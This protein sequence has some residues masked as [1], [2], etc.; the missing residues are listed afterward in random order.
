VQTEP[1][2]VAI[3]SGKDD[4]PEVALG[5]V[6]SLHNGPAALFRQ[7]GSIKGS[8]KICPAEGELRFEGESL[9]VATTPPKNVPFVV[10]ALSS[11]GA[12]AIFVLQGDLLCPSSP[13]KSP[14]LARL[15][16]AQRIL[17]A[18]R[19]DLLEASRLHHPLTAAAEWIIDNPYLIRTQVNEVR[20]HLPRDYAKLLRTDD[21]RTGE[22]R[23]FRLAKELAARAD[24]AIDQGN[25]ADFL[26]E[27]QKEK[28]LTVGE[29]WLFPLLLRVA[30]IEGLAELAQRISRSQNLSELAC[31]WANRLAVSSRGDAAVFDRIV[32]LLS[33]EPRAREPYFVICLSEQLQDEE[34][35]LAPLQRWIEKQLNASVSELVRRE[36]TR[37][38][39]ERLSTANAFGSLRALARI[40]FS[41]IF[42]AVSAVDA[43]LRLDPAGVYSASDF[44]TRDRC[45][46]VVEQIARNS[47]LE[48]TDVAR[49]AVSLAASEGA[50]G[51]DSLQSQVSYYLLDEGVE[52]LERDTRASTPLRVRAMRVMRQHGTE[53]YLGEITAITAC[54]LALAC[55]FAWEGGVHRP[56]LLLIPAALALFPL[57]EL[58]I[59]IINSLVIALF[60]PEPL[61]K[62]DFDAGI[63]REDATLVVVPMML[64]AAEAIRQE[65]D[66]L[67]VRFLANQEKHIQFSLFSDFTDSP[68]PVAPGDAA[69][70]EIARSGIDQLNARYP[71]KHFLLFHRPRT[72]S[73][74]EQL[75]I[76]QERKRGKIGDLNEY[77]C[78]ARPD[79]LPLTGDLLDPIQY[80]I[81]LDSDTQLPPGT[82][83]RMIATIAHP[84][85]RALL[86][87][88][89]HARRR[90]Y[91]VIQP[92]VSVAL[93]GAIASRFTR[94][95]AETK[96]TDPY[97]K[98]VSDAHQDL[99]GEAT[100]H[101]KAIYDVH[102]FREAVGD[103]FPAETILS[104]DLIEGAHA[105]VA[106]ATDIELFENLPLDYAG[107]SK[108]EHRWI[109]GDWQIA[110]W[111][112]PRVP[113]PGGH[114]RPN[115]LSAINRWRIFDNLR[116]SLV[117]IA[118]VLLLL[119]GWLTAAAHGTWSLVVGLA[120]VIPTLAPLMD[121]LARKIQGTALRWRGSEAAFVRALVAVAFLPHQAWIA[122]D[123]I[124]RALYRV[125]VSRRKLLE[126]Q[127]AEEGGI[128]REAHRHSIYLQ[129]LLIS[130]ASL[131]LIVFLYAKG[132]FASAAVFLGLWIVA[133]MLVR[134]L[135]HPDV[136]T[137]RR[138]LSRSDTV[139]LRLLARRTWRFFDDL[140][141]TRSNW[142]PP[143][144]TQLALRVEVAQRTSPTNIG[145]WLTSALA[146]TDLG[147][148]TAEQFLE[149]GEQTMAT[150]G[151]LERYEGH[152]LNWYDTQTLQPLW[153]RYVSTVDSGN[154]MATLWVVSQGCSQLLRRPIVGHACLR[155]LQDTLSILR[156]TYG[157]D[158]SIAAPLQE[159][160][161]LAQK[162]THGHF[163]ISRLMGS[164]RALDGIRESAR[165]HDP[166]DERAY[167]ALRAA[168]ELESWQK[169]S[170]RYLRWMRTLMQPPDSFLH[171]LAPEAV[172][173]RRKAAHSVPSLLDLANG[174]SP[175]LRTIAGWRGPAAIPA[176]VSA[177]LDQLIKEIQEASA[178][179][180]Q[181]VRRFEAFAAACE[182][183]AVGM[184]MRFLYDNDRRLFTV[185]YTVGG[186]AQY[187]SHYDLLASECRLASLVA[188]AKG[189][190]PIQHWFSMSRTRAM[191]G[192]HQVLLSWS[193][194]MFEYL[195]PL[196][197][198]RT[199]DNS[200]LDLACREA[201]R[202][203]IAYGEE[204]QVPWGCSESA[205]S[206]L[207]ANKIYQY[208]A[209][210][211]PS[212]ALKAGVDEDM[213]VAPY[214]T[215][216]A[217]LVDPPK[218]LANLRQLDEL[219]LSGPMGLYE[220]IDF[221]RENKENG[222]PGVPIYAYMAHHQGMSLAAL[223]DVLHRGIMRQRFHADVRVRAVESLLFEGVPITR[224]PSEEVDTPSSPVRLRVTE[225]QA[226]RTWKKEDPASPRIHLQGN[227]RYALMV[228]NSGGGYSQWNGFD[229]T[230]WR[231]DPAID[232]G[233]SYLYIK[234]LSSHA[235]W[236]A[237]QQ[238]VPGAADENLVRFTTD[239][240]EFQR[241][242]RGIETLLAVTVADDDV[243]LR[244]LTVTNQSKRSRQLELTSYIE[245]AMAPHAWD[246][247]HPAFAKMFVQTERLD[248]DVLIAWRRMRE[249]GETPIWTAHLITGAE[250]EILHETDRAKFL[251]RGNTPARPDAVRGRL[252][253][254]TGTVLDP[255]F[256]LS[257]RLEL[258][259]RDRKEITFLTIA[260]SSREEL[261]SI[262]E[263]YRRPEIC[264]RAFEIAWTRS[265]LAFRYLGI[266]P[267]AA[268][269]FQ[270][271]AG[272]LLFPAPRLRPPPDR[273]AQNQLGQSALW[274]HGIS[275]DLPILAVTIADPRNLPLVRELLLAHT[276]CRLLGF[277][278]DLVVLNQEGG[279]YDRPLHQKL[280]HQIE[281]H[282]TE[283]GIDR[284]GGV[285]LRDWDA[286]PE[287]NRQ[288]ILASA[289]VVL[290]GSRGSLQQQ[291][292]GAASTRPLPPAFVPTG[293]KEEPSPP[294]PFLELPYF[295]G[296]G[297]F[298]QDGREY[299][300]Y[301]HD[302]IC[303]PSPWVNVIANP[304]FGTMVSESG[305]GWT[306]HGNSQANRLTPW[307]NDPVTDP[308][309]EVIYLRDEETGAL[310]TPTAL[311][312]REQDAYRARH[313]Q[314]YTVFEHNSHAIEQELI[315]FVPVGPQRND[316]VKLCRLRLRNASS[317]LRRLTVTYFAEW[318]LGSSRELQAPHVNVAFDSD[319]GALF[320]RQSWSG[321]YTR[322]IAFAASS[323][324]A[325]SY[326][327]DR[328]QFLG[329]TGSVA[330]PAALSR[331]NLDNRAIAGSDPCTALQVSVT[332][333]PGK[334]HDI[335]FMLGQAGSL[336]DVRALIR[337]YSAV[338]AVED[339]LRGTREWWEQTLGT[340][341]VRTPV[342]SVDMLMNR[343]LQYQAL[344]CR[345]WARSA[346][347]QSSGAFGFRDQLQDSMAV[348]YAA[349]E[350][351]RQ[352]ILTAAARQFTEGDV[353]H[354]WHP[355]IGTGVRTRCS[356]DF[357]W[358][359][360]VVAHYIKITGDH[361][362]LDAEL[363]FLEAPELAAHEQ[364]RMLTPA[365][366]SNSAPLW[367]H[368]SRALQRG[369]RLGSHSLPL[370][371]N[372]DWNDG[373]NR[374][375]IEGKGES[376][377]LAWFL[378]STLEAFSAA[379]GNRLSEQIR[380]TWRRQA[381]ELTSA[382]SESAWDGEWYLRGFFDDGSPLGSHLDS[383][384]KIDS[385]AQSWAVL[386]GAADPTHA[387][388]AMES[389]ERMLV[390]EGNQLVKLF[391]P[392]FDHSEPN[393]GYIMSYPP[394]LRE[395]GGQY[396]HGSLWMASAWARLGQGDH[397]VHLLTLMNPVEH[398]RDP[399]MAAAYKGE[400]YVCPADVYTAPGRIGQSG[401]TWYTGSAAWMYRIW[402]EDVLG[403]H[404]SG[405]KLTMNPV[406][407][408]NWQGFQIRYR[409]HSATYQ[410]DIERTDEAE[411]SMHLDG[412]AVEAAELSLKDD[413]ALHKVTVRV[414][415]APAEVEERLLSKVG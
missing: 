214:A 334:S 175:A 163:L 235:V 232:R 320:A 101:G 108:R 266:G 118:S 35:A 341:Q 117:P 59:Q 410:I 400:P 253:G 195:M 169:C 246:A 407:P 66:K 147:Y 109:R 251:G 349:P 310:W 285:F 213:V 124:V 27:S 105:G 294:L 317:H 90:G 156:E 233:G 181:T 365:I 94:I 141:G 262:V 319:S 36:H 12:P 226:E 32:Q 351:A 125:H 16:R 85:N 255:V 247:S 49:R 177:W 299:G 333:E 201:V 353:Q 245:L 412:G 21:S 91:T 183:L 270:E 362:I 43:E 176:E 25:L 104:H 332:I 401:W 24:F 84:L 29:L 293:G 330:R 219:G 127:P 308:Q 210:G 228:T 196:I 92:R 390:D 72:W 382:I 379:V 244:R 96:G 342:L 40:D 275:G 159:L 227:G 374:V 216:L 209:F 50:K 302:R 221:G 359:P 220:S 154:L 340:L 99:F 387:R 126:W 134:W 95:F 237:S 97:C 192:G 137:T 13:G 215:M 54:L 86:D 83:R 243:E 369:W 207:D 128:F 200:L 182:Q 322:S 306:W 372:G 256:S 380:Q 77:L 337:R 161:H 130:A 160:R 70:L 223:D 89:T 56:A 297:G 19:Q 277:K 110:P 148:L 102:A 268:H 179:A 321:E 2:I 254:S 346:L 116:R 309:S 212:L 265:Q 393:P 205:F 107:Y 276:F 217:L 53:F 331:K 394:G 111:I 224:P 258:D 384:A 392:P 197:F 414:P 76:G 229:V 65:L 203:Q 22:P 191:V 165:W 301:L 20:R 397:A 186:P 188:I 231:A 280:E 15:K 189:D 211:V 239:R 292:A 57:S 323:P 170:D 328:V 152:L 312:I 263:K 402:L 408:R 377:W 62:L 360:A 79:G 282:S 146:A 157:S 112:F 190:A 355:E 167:W 199:F 38:A 272:Y 166:G 133:P 295:N 6:R 371:G 41:A 361:E 68:E 100:F 71:G 230:R 47:G 52:Q 304:G 283:T 55:R 42:E 399:Q 184:N 358:L 64:S 318:V 236:S 403:F 405:A 122:A 286:L 149:R 51:T 3:Y 44:I 17:E 75:W 391:T 202:Q 376:V 208:R 345:M 385:I 136:P 313:G 336:E 45:R 67:E 174:G 31:F 178:A 48:E 131:V 1:K 63:P 284:P 250:G 34:D 261:L 269:R 142:L 363:P 171:T 123:A 113:G 260:A 8:S 120:V 305:L 386:S 69:L 252:S 143:D 145:L 9:I 311:P 404:L 218:A 350:L 338:P 347:Y 103:R 78:G 114:L 303:T 26:R 151:K 162:P 73:Q 264:S 139:Y 173:V 206:A 370:F 287:Q 327:G 23:A 135:A 368:C 383:E 300:I 168:D 296:L 389:A 398:S 314:G 132:T 367:E 14:I 194:T 257:C 33:A 249:P 267:S 315:V 298:T 343:W 187:T 80:V 307:H 326:S 335:V 121:R 11:A 87:P 381:R 10:K 273:L 138:D 61:P 155:G 248:G 164:S 7:D 28:P 324:R 357:L 37:E 271:L 222:E 388:M 291:L 115:P 344:S 81:T 119:V 74:S 88:A 240:A 415:Y 4:E 60:P 93:P 413:G 150:I 158:P 193:G 140:V 58:S 281:A 339:A 234:D 241:S 144:N 329:R 185:G 98:A 366:S 364:E 396:T 18:A 153:P 375:G 238:P 82:A 172:K 5:S 352:H 325:A 242:V 290:A 378:S 180:A 406:I 348:V 259:P 373:M 225:E 30:L 411:L 289:S 129:M 316:P 274:S 106:L 204:N 278:A 356:D 279:S 409:Y 39:A 395:N 288:L 198:M 354:W 46:K